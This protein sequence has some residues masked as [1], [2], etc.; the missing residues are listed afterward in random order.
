[1]APVWSRSVIRVPGN[2]DVGDRSTGSDR[3]RDLPPADS[4][5]TRQREG[6][7]EGERGH[8]DVENGRI[9]AELA[10]RQDAGCC[11]NRCASRG[12]GDWLTPTRRSRTVAARPTPAVERVAST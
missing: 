12:F 5:D 6:D 2:D 4:G 7:A 9:D 11:E 8:D 3:S 10:E 1:M